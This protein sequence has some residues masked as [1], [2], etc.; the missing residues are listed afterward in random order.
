MCI[1]IL[2]FM[3]NIRKIIKNNKTIKKKIEKLSKV[4]FEKIKSLEDKIIAPCGNCK[5]DGM[6]RCEACRDNYYSGYN[7]ENYP[8]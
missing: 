2:S 4:Y 1:W 5:Y 7:I 8:R 3:N 6:Y